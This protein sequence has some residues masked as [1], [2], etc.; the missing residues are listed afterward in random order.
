MSTLQR[1]ILAFALVVAIGAGQGLFTLYNLNGVREQVNFV[2]SKPIAG[3][4]NARAA[5]SAYRD[6]RAHLSNFLEMT[7]PQESQAAL[8]TFNAQVGVLNGHLEKLKDATTGVAAE[9]LKAA[10]AD[11]ARWQQSARVLLGAAPATSIPAPH[12][13]AK[14]DVTIHKSLDELV[15]LALKDAD[16]VR[17]EVESSIASSTRLSLILMV[18]GI[19]LSGALA[20]F[21]SLA[22]SRPL[23]R[24]AGTMRQL[25]EGRLEVEV[26]DKQ[27]RDEIGNMANALEVFRAS[28]VEVQRLEAQNKLNEQNAASERR[29]MLAGVA[30]RFQ[31]QV[32]GIVDRVIETVSGVE[33]SATTMTQ[34][35]EETRKRVDDVLGASTAASGNISSVASA[36]EEMATT[37]GEI[38]QRSDQSHHIASDAVTRV[39][40]SGTVIT[41][42]TDSTARIGKIVDLIGDIAA[43]TNLLAL[44]ATIEAARAGEAGRG[45]AVVASEVKSLA[46]QTSKATGEIS[47][48]IAQVQETTKQAAAAMSA[49]QETI[50]V[51]DGSAAEVAG[52][53]EQQRG[54]IGEISRNTQSASASA[55][56]VTSN[57]QELH[58]TFAEVGSA[59][60]DIR[61][62]IGS[63]GESVHV[64]RAETET[65]LKDVLAA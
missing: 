4:D 32:A 50:R 62:K 28:A 39:E 21:L 44:N 55:V 47:S 13:L 48:Q 59:S 7:R 61:A 46:D 19:V 53:I 18:A 33:R 24:L 15:A 60:N 14:M 64:L 52:A 5:W 8:S 6:A 36:A 11:V 29:E 25:S 38:A 43:Q 37:S 45:F 20:I 65:F 9:K 10:T 22:M 58:A 34:I 42:L 3:V 56:Q 26:T 40:A 51:I 41:S 63:L 49:I 1:M 17:T 57:L 30:N 31:T 16:T 23:I 12:A 27:R 54:A 35:A 2:A